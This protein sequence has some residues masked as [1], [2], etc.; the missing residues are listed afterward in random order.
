MRCGRPIWPFV[1]ALAGL[2]AFSIA[3]DMPAMPG[4]AHHAANHPTYTQVVGAYRIE[5]HL[6]PPEEFYTAAEVAAKH[7][8]EGMLIVGGFPPLAVGATPAPNHHL[9]VHVFDRSTGMAVTDAKVQMS[10]RRVGADGHPSG[11]HTE[12]PV[13]TMQ[14][15]GAGA[16][17]THYGNNLVIPAGAYVVTVIINHTSTTARF[18]IKI[19]S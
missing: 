16:A 15:I 18:P 10:F 1:L 9:I 3:A 4:M 7:I 11:P 2:P 6:L 8:S 12:V 13:V 5:L 19:E 14:A 17:S